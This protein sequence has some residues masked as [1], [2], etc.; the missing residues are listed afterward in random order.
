M[1]YPTTIATNV[2]FSD[3]IIIIIIW[4]SVLLF[5]YDD[6]MYS[7]QVY[8]LCYMFATTSICGRLVK[9][10]EMVFEI[11]FFFFNMFLIG[12]IAIIA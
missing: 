10:F 9:K 7:L 4:G 2:I 6:Y 12:C 3:L 8:L 11:T 1:D 5:Q